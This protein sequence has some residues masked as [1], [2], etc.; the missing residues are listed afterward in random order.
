MPTLRP[1]AVAG[2]FYPRDRRDLEIAVR[3]YLDEAV[4]SCIVPRAVI[5]PH[6]GYIYSG[7]IA[8]SACAPLA[9]RRGSVRRV[10]VAGPSHHISVHG[11]AVPSAR[12]FATPIGEI[13]ID[14]ATIE[15]LLKLPGVRVDDAAHA[16]EHSIEVELPFLHVV[17]GDFLLVPLVIGVSRAPEAAAILA[18][19]WDDET[20]FVI[21]SDLSHYLA[22]ETARLRDARTSE[23]IVALDDAALRYDDACGR[24][25]VNALLAFSRDIRLTATTVDLRNSG[26]TAGDRKRVV[27]YGAFV[28]A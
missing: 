26:D 25:S 3:G 19:L 2:S 23:N 22:Y 1:P 18:S 12:A 7:P 14:R 6:A 10:V 4:P 24:D 16:E 28:F 21:S 17:L 5:M 11:I 20:L 27:G 13:P 15:Q 9:P 8:A